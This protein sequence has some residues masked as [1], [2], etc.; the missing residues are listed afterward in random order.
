MDSTICAVTTRPDAL[1]SS[2]LLSRKVC[3]TVELGSEAIGS[4]HL[5]VTV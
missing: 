2:G 4:R 3:I 1:A 5:A